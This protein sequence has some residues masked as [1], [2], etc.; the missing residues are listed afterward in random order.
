VAPSGRGHSALRIPVTAG[1]GEEVSIADMAI[2]VEV[3]CSAG[4]VPRRSPGGQPAI[5]LSVLRGTRAAPR[6]ERPHT[7][8]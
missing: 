2:A 4:G 8:N 6:M 7:E 5:G 1:G 3:L